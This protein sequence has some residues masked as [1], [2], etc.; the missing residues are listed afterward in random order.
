MG[1]LMRWLAVPGALTGLLLAAGATP[2]R[3]TG[4][5]DCEIA[6]KT[7][8]FNAASAFSYSIGGFNNFRGALE[9]RAKDVPA[10]LAKFEFDG[11]ALLHHWF[12]DKELKLEV[13]RE[14]EGAP[15]GTVRLVVET[16]KV[17]G[18][19]GSYRGTYV[20]ELFTV[21]EGGG[22]GRTR[23]FKGKAACSAE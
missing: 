1:K 20:L 3:A 2:A 6:D 14:R 13:Y 9:L 12:S 4:S 16:R 8:T 17:A 18:S 11:E 10:D 7:V 22:E 21:P 23:T 5:L 19:E 15:H